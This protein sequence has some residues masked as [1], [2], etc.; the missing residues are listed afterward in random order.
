MDVVVFRTRG[1]TEWEEGGKR[2]R[3]MGRGCCAGYG[4]LERIAAAL[5]AGVHHER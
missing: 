4:R 5:S 2:R 3:R 1:H